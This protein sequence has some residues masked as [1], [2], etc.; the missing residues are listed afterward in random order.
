MDTPLVLKILY[1]TLFLLLLLTIVSLKPAL[2]Q[3]DCAQ[4]ERV[5]Y[6]GASQGTNGVDFT[7][8]V[9]VSS[10]FAGSEYIAC[11]LS[12]NNAFPENVCESDK[13]FIGWSG[14]IGT[15]ECTDDLPSGS[16]SLVA[17]DFRS[18][19]GPPKGISVPIS[20]NQ[21]Q[22]PSVIL[23]SPKPTSPT[24]YIPITPLQQGGPASMGQ[25]IIPNVPI[26][27]IEPKTGPSNSSKE[28]KALR[29]LDACKPPIT[30]RTSVVNAPSITVQGMKNIL[31]SYESPAVS[32]AEGIYNLGVQYGIDP[33]M[34]LVFFAK[35]SSMGKYGSGAPNK[36]IG[37]IECGGVSCGVGGRFKKYNTWTEGSKDWYRLIKEVYVDDWGLYYIETILPTYAPSNEND[38][39]LYISQI[40][41]W[42]KTKFD[43]K[44][45]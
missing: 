31:R 23:G 22:S 39:C 38:T 33:M 19:C 45:K 1:K 43:G 9:T 42:Y 30:S 3:S 29:Q 2:A 34:L 11:G 5:E 15:Y 13:R 24:P 17:Y 20:F 8:K 6:V 35:E 21:E 27:T 44:D 12:L 4:I 36:N 32:E 25:A 26:P 7:C 16:K 41:S 18:H 14:N 28:K 10:Q 37:N 40:T